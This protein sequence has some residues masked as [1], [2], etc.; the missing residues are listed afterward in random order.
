MQA[1]PWTISGLRARCL[2]MKDTIEA[3]SL[4]TKEEVAA[5]WPGGEHN[6]A[7]TLGGWIVCYGQMCSFVGRRAVTT[8][9]AERRERTMINALRNAPKAVPLIS[10]IE[11][12]PATLYVHPK[13]ADA[14]WTLA[15]LERV[16]RE[17]ILW[18]EAI[19]QQDPQP[20]E[21]MTALGHIARMLARLHAIFAWIVTCPG[22]G[23]P[24]MAHFAL[25]WDLAEEPPAWCTALDAMDLLQLAQAHTEVNLGRLQALPKLAPA[26]PAERGHGWA[27]FFQSYA[28]EAKIPPAELMAWHPMTGLLTASALAAEAF[29]RREA[30]RTRGKAA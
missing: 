30:E 12:Q 7:R 10:P 11:G 16:L 18:R 24:Y 21:G 22:P 3:R 8:A 28:A 2:R 1:E 17:T 23:V 9:E 29:Q 15:E 27:T 25:P 14:L 6:R 19:L 26:D 20:P 4:A 13:G 5:W